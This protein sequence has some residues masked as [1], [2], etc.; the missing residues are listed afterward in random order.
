MGG[1][2][3]LVVAIFVF[4]GGVELLGAVAGSYLFAIGLRDLRRTS[5]DQAQVPAIDSSTSPARGRSAKFKRL[6]AIVVV[7]VAFGVIG[8]AAYF[9]SSG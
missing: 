7:A 2:V 3:L 4:A 1:V 6:S 5:T 9:G 8:L